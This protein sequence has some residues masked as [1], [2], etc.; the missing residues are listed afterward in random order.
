MADDCYTRAN[1]PAPDSRRIPLADLGPGE[2]RWPL[3]D[4]REEAL[5]FCAAAERD[6]EGNALTYCPF[7]SQLGLAGAARVRMPWGAR[8][9]SR[10]QKTLKGMWR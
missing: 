10:A 9:G 8:S 1:T 3:G 5:G 7:H 6:G 4:P 2:C